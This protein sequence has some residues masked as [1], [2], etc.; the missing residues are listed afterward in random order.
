VRNK[1]VVEEG[2][3]WTW[4]WW[5]MH[6]RRASESLNVEEP[7]MM[8]KGKCMFNPRNQTYYEE[9]YITKCQSL[10][11]QEIKW[12]GYQKWKLII[13]YGVLQVPA[14]KE[15]MPKWDQMWWPSWSQ[16]DMKW[17]NSYCVSSVEVVLWHFHWCCY[18][19]SPLWF[20]CWRG[21]W[22]LGH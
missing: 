17:Q 7:Y 6:R 11:N 12:H 10:L 15:S 5:T 4:S 13:W 21:L 18:K 3:T 19:S 2:L 1:I 20:F 16:K 22:S 9:S 14:S 8:E